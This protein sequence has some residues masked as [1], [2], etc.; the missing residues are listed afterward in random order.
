MN[1]AQQQKQPK[2]TRTFR[3]TAAP[4]RHI[5]TQQGP[6][7]I[8]W[9]AQRALSSVA[10]YFRALINS[11]LY[12]FTAIPCIVLSPQTVSLPK[13]VTSFALGF[14]LLVTPILL[15]QAF[16]LVVVAVAATALICAFFTLAVPAFREWL[17]PA[18]RG[19]PLDASAFNH[20]PTALMFIMGALPTV[21]LASPLVFVAYSIAHV[22]IHFGNIAAIAAAAVPAVSGGRAFP[23]FVQRFDGHRI[24]PQRQPSRKE[25]HAKPGEIALHLG[26]ATG[27]LAKRGNVSSIRAN[28]PIVLRRKDL[29]L[30]FAFIGDPGSGKTAGG[31]RPLIHQLITQGGVGLLILDG[32]GEISVE[33][34]T[35]AKRLKRKVYRIGVESLG[36][37]LFDGLSPDQISGI[38]KQVFDLTGTGGSSGNADFFVT[39]AVTRCKNILG[40][41]QP[42]PDHYSI[43]GLRSYLSNDEFRKSILKQY[44]ALLEKNKDGAQ[45]LLADYIDYEIITWPK[46]EKAQ[47]TAGG[48]IATIQNVF[49]RFSA[50][51]LAKAFCTTS[52]GQAKLAELDEGAIFVVDLPLNKY[53][54][55]AQ[56]VLVF[57]KEAV[58]RLIK[59]RGT[60]SEEQR[61]AKIPIGIVADEYQ[62]IT[63]G[64]SDQSAIEVSRSL[65]GFMAVSFQNINSLNA[66]I[67]NQHTARSL[68]ANL[69]QK[70]IFRTNDP[71]TIRYVSDALGEAEITIHVKSWNHGLSGGDSEQSSN[72]GP[73]SG[74]NRGWSTGES[75]SEQRHRQAIVNS[76]TFRSL[77]QTPD[78]TQGIAMLTINENAYDDI[79]TVP[80]IYNSHMMSA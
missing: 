13:L 58:F 1:A 23:W 2:Q 17:V 21:L 41:L 78:T 69:S 77:E 63:G 5:P 28:E 32:K 70:I 67:P 20:T 56:V 33:A 18:L 34:E 31:I 15:I 71:D 40:V 6:N 48:I 43:S 3:S 38:L 72:Q 9:L 75:T 76:Q 50:P 62:K 45:Q 24:L 29:M 30:S 54:F 79:I 19:E 4:Q 52:A 73:S 57:L 36:L 61:Q 55:A 25:D 14:V 8:L 68:L 47:S 39:Q 46:I 64:A 7:P 53:D 26:Y 44:A 66:A 65:G 59:A 42:F 16:L 27:Q 74:W 35:L 10:W 22:F 51:E 11:W 49:D 12:V 80:K 60:L 37:N